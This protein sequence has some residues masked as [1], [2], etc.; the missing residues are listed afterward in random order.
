MEPAGP[1]LPEE[2]EVLARL[3]A[4]DLPEDIVP[5]APEVIPV[6]ALMA[7]DAWVEGRTVDSIA[8]AP[9]RLPPGYGRAAPGGVRGRRPGAVAPANRGFLRAL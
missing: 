2:P 5:V 8:Y 4:G 7:E 1:R 6:W 9:R 3:E